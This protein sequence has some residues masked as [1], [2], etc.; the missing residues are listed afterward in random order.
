MVKTGS[1]LSAR[2]LGTAKLSDG[3]KQVTYN[4]HPLY[5]YAGDRRNTTTAGEGAHQFGGR[6]YVVNAKGNEVKP[7]QAPSNPCNPVCTGY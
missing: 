2:L 3:R 1:G 6:W 7:K 4:H 5:T